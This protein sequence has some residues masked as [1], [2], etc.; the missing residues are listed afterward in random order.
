[1]LLMTTHEI[2]WHTTPDWHS[3]IGCS[4]TQSCQ[5]LLN[6]TTADCCSIARC[7]RCSRCFITTAAAPSCLEVAAG[8]CLVLEALL[9]I[10]LPWPC[11]QQQV[12]DQGI[13]LLLLLILMLLS[14]LHITKCMT[15]SLW[16]QQ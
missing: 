10:T 6:S 4:A 2:I 8:A 13:T 7:S 9:R 14:K 3:L 5:Q 1:M 16:R 15:S 11:L 12:L